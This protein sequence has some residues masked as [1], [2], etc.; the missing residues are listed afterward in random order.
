MKATPVLDRR[1]ASEKRRMGALDC[2]HPF[3]FGISQ[4]DALYNSLTPA[5][6]R[7]AIVPT[8]LRRLDQAASLSIRLARS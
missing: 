6:T 8:Q 2:T 5:A 4:S 1:Q 3:G 7:A